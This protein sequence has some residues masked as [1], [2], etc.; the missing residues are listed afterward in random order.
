MY[1][2]KEKKFNSSQNKDKSK[3]N[4]N[5]KNEKKEECDVS[6]FV[7]NINNNKS[8]IKVVNYFL[9]Q[10]IL[11]FLIFEYAFEIL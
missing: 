11:N 3:F 7:S 6:N 1:N 2:K 8:Q 10:Y 9:H 5:N 4:N